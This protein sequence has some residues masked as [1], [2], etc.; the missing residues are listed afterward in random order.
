M[1]P[2]YLLP[3]RLW[4]ALLLGAALTGCANMASHDKLATEMQT[5]GQSAGIP[6]AL[7]KLD[8]SA[9]TEE[10]KKALLYNLER[11]E[12]L[13]MDR[14]YEDS[15]GA[16][17]RADTKVK[18]WEETAKTSPEKLLGTVGAALISERLKPYEGQDYEKVWLTTRLALNRM[19][20][21][22]FEN[23]RVDIKR[24]HER[25]AVIAEFRAKETLAAEEE[26]KAKGATSGSKELNG[27]PVETLNDPEVLE[28]KNGYSNA[29][30]HYLAG[31]LY[32]VL[33]ESG[34]AAPG[35]RKAIELKP[36]TG[37]L[38]E[39]LRGLDART[40][41]TWKRKQRMTDVLFLVEAGDAPA[42][43]PKAFTLPV[44]TGSGVVA[45]SVSYPVIEPSND[46]L[47]GQISAAG[48]DFKLEKVVDVNVMARRALKD[49]MPGMVF[50]GMTRA[51]AKG[52]LQN[53]M[54]KRGGLIGGL[55][56]AAATVATEQAD[57]RM[58]RMLPGRVYVARGYLPPGEHRLSVN[59][60][61]L[62]EPIQIDGQY[63]LVPLRI[64][65]NS[66]LTGKVASLGQLP[67]MAAAP[68]P[69][70]PAVTATEPA[71]TAPK[72]AARSV[73]RPGTVPAPKAAA[74]K[75]AA[76]KAA[77]Q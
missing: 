74:P 19:A 71:A 55:I 14:R 29:L 76:P 43:K 24:T 52:V 75:A 67:A 27:Y 41:F 48:F 32:E 30:S 16:F 61:P 57:D 45:V 3:A 33:G 21:G 37:V 7:A 77:V 1:T 18:E 65:H 20:Q 63:A 8:A 62:P 51:I 70:A 5:A 2:W 22:D 59:G 69:A 49:E 40:S 58:W 46:P 68:A 36:N 35:Y 66:V 17:L 15:T 11:G 6:A 23:A 9:P 28:L 44:P 64:Y 72:P 31:F 39:G 4:G 12:L 56:A 60:R 73:R 50:R 13:R 25:E 54:Q 34:L 53:E 42:R 26:A 47:L 10:D 38:E